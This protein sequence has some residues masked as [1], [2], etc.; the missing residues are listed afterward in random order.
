MAPTGRF[1]DVARL[2]EGQR[3]A[4]L[5]PDGPLLITAGPGTGKTATL[6]ERIAHL[7]QTGRASLTDVLTLTFSRAA[8]QTLTAR[9]VARLGPAGAAVQATTFH[10]FGLWLI[11][12]WAGE[13]GYGVANLTVCD[14]RDARALLLEALGGAAVEPPPDETLSAL[15]A[16]V[17][18]ARLAL[19]QGDTP[20]AGVARL[21]ADYERLLRERGAVDF[22]SM[23]AEPL[24]LFREHP[25]I[26]RRYQATY[27]WI[28]VDE[29]QDLA[30]PQ[31]AL[32]R[33]LAAGHGNLTVV[34]DACQN[35]YDWRGADATFLLDFAKTYPEARVVRLT[36]N[37]RSTG[38]ILAVA[39]A[40][41][42]TLPYGQRLWTANPP[43]SPPT[44]HAAHDAADEAAFVAAEI[45]RLLSAGVIAQPRAVAVLARTNQQAGPIRAALRA[46]GLPYSNEAV[47]NDGVRVGTI[48]A[49]KGDEWDAVFVVGMEEDLLPHRRALD[50]EAAGQ[51]PGAIPLAGELHTA[52][53]AVTRPRQRLYLT[54][55]QRREEPE[56]GGRV[57]TRTC[58]PSRFLELL[59]AE[60]LHRAA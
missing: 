55:C 15:A 4:V 51:P 33:L 35:L 32:L 42:A 52:Y 38:N 48:H 13:L 10:A 5:A 47:G 41:G 12:R 18:E 44:L 45:A 34:G 36:E 46:Q 40:L 20:L 53:V 27:R 24:R 56:P 17:D 57:A 7:I 1:P 58:R 37:F 31:Y 14:A 25:H 59:P 23:L 28:L 9:L 8:A 16:A 29:F 19:A 6:A 11:Q 2:S 50:A 3:E 22:A 60:N 54:Y 21:A 30:A 26:L 49:A 43:G 39:N